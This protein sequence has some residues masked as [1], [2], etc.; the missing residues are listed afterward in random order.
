MES[1]ILF[2]TAAAHPEVLPG[3][4]RI[5]DLYAARLES[6]KNPGADHSE[7]LAEVQKYVPQYQTDV[8]WTITDLLLVPLGYA[9]HEGHGSANWGESFQRFRQTE[10]FK[11]TIRDAGILAYWQEHRWPPLCRPVGNDD[12]ECD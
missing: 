12:F 1:E 11:Q 7:L 9:K 4:P 3:F 5:D 8:G 10:A 6:K 2:M